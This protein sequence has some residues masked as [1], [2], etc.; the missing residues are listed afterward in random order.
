[1]KK[2][3]EI[4]DSQVF[5]LY[6]AGWSIKDI[7]V[8]YKI[9]VGRVRRLLQDKKINTSGYRAA[10]AFMKEIILALLAQGCTLKRLGDTADVSVHLVRQ[11]LRD[12]KINCNDLRKSSLSDYRHKQS[13]EL[14]SWNHFLELYRSG[15]AGFEKCAEICGFSVCECVEAVFRLNHEDVE[16]HRK[17]LEEY[18]ISHYKTGLSVISVA[19]KVGV[20]TAIVK[21][22][23]SQLYNR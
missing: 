7:S 16:L 9:S 23:F 21:K 13:V 1:M 10:S 11:V 2:K 18:I 4:L 20:S 8:Q 6:N 14:S 3:K 17:N 15:H 22:I 12:N 19:K 5:T